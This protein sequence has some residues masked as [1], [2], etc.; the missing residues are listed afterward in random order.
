MVYLY[1]SPTPTPTSPPFLTPFPPFNSKLKR[2]STKD[3][4]EEVARELQSHM[5]K[6][7]H[8]DGRKEKEKLRKEY[9]EK[10]HELA[11]QGITPRHYNS[12]V[13]RELGL[14]KKF[15]SMSQREVERKLKNTRER[16]SKKEKKIV[17]DAM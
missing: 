4:K 12:K 15:L 7:R 2:A 5:E 17:H 9:V 11:E 8:I 14:A 16:R 1:T 3:E 6:K 13:G 10:Q